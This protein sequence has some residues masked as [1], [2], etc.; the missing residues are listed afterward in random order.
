M[1]GRR[2]IDLSPDD[3]THIDQIAAFLFECFSKYSPGW[4]ADKA[5]CYRQITHSFNAD[6]C[7]RVMVDEQDQAIGWIAAITDE[8]CWEIH[9]IAVKPGQRR[10]GIGRRLVADIEQLA[11]TS[12]AVS[13]WAGTSDETR[14]TSFSHLDLYKNPAAGFIDI[15]APDDHPVTFWRSVGYKVVGVLP[16][17]EG[18]GKPGIHFARRLV[19]SISDEE[20]DL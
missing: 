12:G 20:S 5:A 11:I 14:S 15:T 10:S 9:P 19:D 17:E 3:Q 7:S 18:L 13:V 6:R 1:S 16:D 2:I 4:L 8:H